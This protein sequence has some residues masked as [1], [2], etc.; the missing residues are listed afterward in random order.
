MGCLKK[1][2]L[3][4]I[5]A[6]VL[7]FV[8]FALKDSANFRKNQSGNENATQSNYEIIKIEKDSNNNKCA[9]YVLVDFVNGKLP[10]AEVLVPIAK[11]VRSNSPASEKTFIFFCVHGID[12]EDI[13]WASAH[14]PDNSKIDVIREPQPTEIANQEKN[15][16]NY[17]QRRRLHY[18]L[19]RIEGDPS[20]SVDLSDKKE[21]SRLEALER[22]AE[23]EK[24]ALLKRY[25]ISQSQYTELLLES[26]N[27]QW[28]V[29]KHTELDKIINSLPSSSKI[30]A[31]RLWKNND[32]VFQV[33]AKYLGRKENK[34][35]L[36]RK[37][38]KGDIAVPQESLSEAD[39]TWIN[40]NDK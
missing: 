26:Y 29:P 3:I 30:H 1:M 4:C 5:S 24:A 37:D 14:D 18:E 16:L 38:G 13:T 35:Q 39:K 32:G 15:G 21:K 17:Q 22:K 36:R 8:V 34:I 9:Y 40:I 31:F 20:L 28:K 6:I 19:L 7:T 33:E 25:E 2:L 10:S 11:E 23:T 27:N 12:N